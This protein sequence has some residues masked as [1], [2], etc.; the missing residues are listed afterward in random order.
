[1]FPFFTSTTST[2]FGHMLQSVEGGFVF[3]NDEKE[4][5]LLNMIRNHGMYRHLPLENQEKYKNPDVSRDIIP[6]ELFINW[7]LPIILC[8]G[9]FD[10]IA[11]KSRNLIN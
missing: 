11:I 1:M 2:Y 5:E 7:D 8:E 6:F 3:T 4:Y 9:L 10:A